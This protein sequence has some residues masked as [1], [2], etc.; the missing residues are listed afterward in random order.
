MKN[1]AKTKPS[2]P[3]VECLS[4]NE[5]IFV[6]RHARLGSYVTC[7]NCDMRFVITNFDPII[8]DWFFDFDD[9]FD[10]DDD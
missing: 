7:S 6:N 9:V 3:A 8:V 4:C 10:H 2:N 1:Q 5:S